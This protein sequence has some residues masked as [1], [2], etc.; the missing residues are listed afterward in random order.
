MRTATGGR[1]SRELVDVLEPALGEHLGDNRRIRHIERRLSDYRSSFAIEELQVEF[2]DG[3]IVPV[4]FKDLSPRALLEEARQTRPAFLYDPHREIEVYRRLLSQHQLGTAVCYL[5]VVDPR[6]DRYW[7][8]MEKVQGLELYQIGDFATWEQVAGWLARFHRLAPEMLPHAQK[9]RLLEWNPPQYQA[10]LEWAHT[11]QSVRP[12]SRPASGD[13]MERITGIYDRVIKRLAALPPAVIHGEF[14]ASNVLVQQTPSGVRVCP[15]DWETAG[16]G[17]GL[18]DLAALV[19]GGWTDQQREALALAYWKEL[20]DSQ[21]AAFEGQSSF[22]EGLL[23]CRL[24]LALQLLGRSPTWEPPPEHSQDWLQ[25]ADVL[26]ANLEQ[27][28]NSRQDQ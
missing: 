24:L 11:C 13:V 3:R 14:Y 28:L 25:E 2:D 21:R 12:P 10:C 23:A 6:R 27:Q 16:V 26:A 15:I 19:A 17:P 9:T 1:D 18:I 8:F 4:M 7:L 5:A 22:Y 20:D